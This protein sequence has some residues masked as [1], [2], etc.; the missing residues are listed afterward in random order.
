MLLNKLSRKKS[1]FHKRCQVGRGIGCGKGKTCG[2]G[3]KGQKSRSGVSLS[4]FEGG[5]QPITRRL[6]KRGFK[7]LNK[8]KFTLINLVKI[9][10]IVQ[11]TQV[12]TIDKQYLLQHKVIENTRYPIKVLAQKDYLLRNKITLRVDAIS[13]SARKMI[14]DKEG[15]VQIV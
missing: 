13:K 12:Y 7:S 15:T 14:E 8:K 9:D 11:N 1:A 4:G 6:P 2:K 3:H 5:Q 10:E